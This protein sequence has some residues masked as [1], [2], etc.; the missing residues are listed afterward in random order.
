[1]N[2]PLKSLLFTSLFLFAITACSSE[3]SNNSNSDTNNKPDTEVADKPDMPDEPD[4][5]HEGTEVIYSD[6]WGAFKSAVANES[7]E[8]MKYYM[9]L[10]DETADLLIGMITTEIADAMSKIP[11]DQLKDT[12]WEEKDVKEYVYMESGVD[13][14]GNDTGMAL[15][16]YFQ[17][18]E[19]GLR[20]I[21][22]MAAG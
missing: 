21:G 3:S 7:A 4:L 9:K 16:F 15:Y 12:K 20:L 6:D 13:E 11:Y 10:D 18:Q 14:E 5:G 22:Y 1:M 2:N 19:E 8:G 17:E